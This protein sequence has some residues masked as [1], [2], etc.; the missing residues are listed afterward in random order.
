MASI[1]TRKFRVHNAAQFFESVTEAAATVYYMGIGRASAWSDDLNPPTPT[2][3]LANTA[4]AYWTDLFALKKIAAT[5]LSHAVVRTDWAANTVYTQFSHRD[6]TPNNFYVLSSSFNVYKCLYN[7]NGAN[8]TVEPTGTGNTVITTGDGYKWKFLYQISTTEAL[9]FLTSTF[10]PV[11][12]LTANDSS[13]QW[14]VQQYAGT[15][16]GALDIVQMTAGGSGYD[17]NTTTVSIVGDGSGAVISPTIVANSITAITVTSRGS[18]Y[19]RANVV[20]ASSGVG[21]GAAAFPM[22]PPQGY[23][24][25]DPVKELHGTY[26]MMTGR[27][28][29]SEGN[30]IPT[31][32]AFRRIMMIKDPKLASNGAVAANSVYPQTTNL[33]LTSVTGAYAQ[34]ETVTGGT[35]GAT[36][37]VIDYNQPGNAGV[38]R[39]VSITGTFQVAELVTGGTSS[40]IG[41]TSVVTAPAVAPYTGDTLYIEQRSPITR[42][43]DQTEILRVILAF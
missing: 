3:A 38:L 4:Y 29:T 26:I 34:G 19:S 22:I 10:M 43:N 7:N 9:N 24:G 18:N 28:S 40:A 20:I 21:V 27:F 35:S 8:S 13:L 31:D 12:T 39:I 16:N 42:A 6:A 14:S 5:D 23:H 33:T 25:S 17:A 1:N 32:V 41:T 36:A 30:T 2:D 15:S 11:K 37:T